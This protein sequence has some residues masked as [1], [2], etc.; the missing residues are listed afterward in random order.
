MKSKSGVV[1]PGQPGSQILL[2]HQKYWL[3]I[4]NISLMNIAA[5]HLECMPGGQLKYGRYLSAAVRHVP[6][7][8]TTNFRNPGC[9]LM[10]RRFYLRGSLMYSQPILACDL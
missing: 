4:T 9:V 3:P 10:E 2:A 6:G 7:A 5:N 8:R 1:V